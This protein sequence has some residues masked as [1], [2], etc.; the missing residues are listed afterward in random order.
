MAARAASSAGAAALV[1]PKLPAARRVARTSGRFA[2]ADLLERLGA[3]VDLAPHERVLAAVLAGDR[4]AGEDPGALAR[5]RAARPGLVG[6]AAVAAGADAVLAAS[7]FHFGPD[8]M[9]ARVKDALRQAGHT[10]R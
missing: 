2:V 1:A 9:L 7:L 8:D 3:A 10:V 6:W 4:S 5:A